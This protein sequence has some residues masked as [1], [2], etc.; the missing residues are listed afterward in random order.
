MLA[1]LF[2][3]KETEKKG[4]GLFAKEFIPK[5]TIVCFECDKCKVLSA[6]EIGYD[7]MSVEEKMKLLDYAYRKEDGTF[8]V[9]CG[10]IR[11]LNHSCNANILTANL[12][13]DIVVRDIEKGE[14]ATYDYRDFYEDVK[15]PCR[16]GE[17]NCCRIVEF[18]HPVPNGLR[19][20]WQKNI[21][22][23][24]KYVNKVEQ[25]LKEELKQKSIFFPL[26]TAKK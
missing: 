2:E 6:S 20:F 4:K 8:I 5:G 16:C 9:P 15:M 25:P 21:D 24:L 14:E 22:F 17:K 18:V 13:F 3:V 1:E 10:D 19:E 7:K 12:G 11:Y 23:A 26:D